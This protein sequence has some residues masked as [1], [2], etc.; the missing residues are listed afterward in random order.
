MKTAITKLS[1]LTLLAGLVGSAQAVQVFSGSLDIRDNDPAGQ[2]VDFS[3][4]NLPSSIADMTVTLNIIPTPGGDGGYN[5]DLFVYLKNNSANGGAGVTSVLLNRTGLSLS[6]NEGYGDQGF[7][8]T[9]SM[10]A[11][12]DIHTYQDDSSYTGT[13]PITGTWAADGRLNPGAGLTGDDRTVKLD[14]FQGVNPNGNW[15]LFL[16]DYE[17]SFTSTLTGVS[18]DIT[19]VPEPAQTAIAFAGL[20]FGLVLYRRPE[21]RERLTSLV[22]R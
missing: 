16:A 13:A 11:V 10:A 15:T 3:L 6:N 22:R 20:L 1:I 8:V 12:P 4:S 5:G 18:V 7:A 2:S 14:V 9:F 19:A 21:I 17:T